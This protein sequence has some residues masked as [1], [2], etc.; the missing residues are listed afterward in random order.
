MMIQSKRIRREIMLSV[1]SGDQK[2]IEKAQNKQQHLMKEQTQLN[3]RKMKSS[4]LVSL[5]MMLLWPSL[6]NLFDGQ[7]L[8]ILPFNIPFIPQELGFGYWYFFVSIT[9]NLIVNR[10][11]GLTFEFDPEEIEEF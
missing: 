5:P 2:K 9:V 4:M 6:R 10:L 8:A 7:T 3:Q 11:F 1:R